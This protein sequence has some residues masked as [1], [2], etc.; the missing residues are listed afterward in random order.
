MPLISLLSSLFRF[1]NNGSPQA[2]QQTD[3][4]ANQKEILHSLEKARLE[5]EL[6]AVKSL[7]GH[8]KL[9]RELFSRFLDHRK[10]DRNDAFA[11]N[12]AFSILRFDQSRDAL[13]KARGYLEESIEYAGTRVAKAPH[14]FALGLM[15]TTNG[16]NCRSEKS[17]AASR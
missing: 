13:E 8:E 6:A 7:S 5:F 16:K 10:Q 4:P 15:D 3:S 14:I 2:Q 17:N 9:T 1:F 12:M 11:S